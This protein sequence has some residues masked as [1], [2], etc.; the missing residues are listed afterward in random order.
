ML[1]PALATSP[2]QLPDQSVPAQRPRST[3]FTTAEILP[4]YDSHN[5][6][7]YSTRQHSHKQHNTT[8]TRILSGVPKYPQTVLLASVLMFRSHVCPIPMY[9]TLS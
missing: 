6:C 3:Y 8:R 4:M 5:T 1:N 2:S 7:D 9:P